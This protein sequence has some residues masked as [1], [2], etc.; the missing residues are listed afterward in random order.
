[1][2]EYI[3]VFKNTHDAIEAEKSINAKGI[4]IIVMPTP[5]HITQSCGISIRFKEEE[6]SKVEELAREEKVKYKNI[7]IKNNMQFKLYK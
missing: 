5:T 7:Y 3:I 1:M 2:N 6:L 4:K